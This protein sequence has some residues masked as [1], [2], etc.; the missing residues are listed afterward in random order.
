VTI[1]DVLQIISYDRMCAVCCALHT[2][3]AVVWLMQE[4]DDMDLRSSGIIDKP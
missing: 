3:Q 2:A 1:G 4:M